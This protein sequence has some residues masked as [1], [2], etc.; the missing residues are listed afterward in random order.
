[1]PR[2]RTTVA[3]AA[4]LAVTVGGCGADQETPAGAS[5]A[6]QQVRTV[7]AKFGIATRDKDYQVICNQLLAQTLVQK[8]EAV[9]LPCEGAL[10]RGL[11]DVKSPTLKINDVSISHGRALVSVHTTAAG[12]QPSDDALQLVLEGRHWKIASLA[13]PSGPQSGTQTGATTTT[14]T[15]SP[16]TTTPGTSTTTTS[17][18]SR[19]TTAT[20]KKK[21]G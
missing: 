17:T 8:I 13:A 12:Q 7:V 18:T 14:T 5:S 15:T 2:R 1:V 6:D 20:T 16:S 10:Q 9:G 19:S 21:G 3:F 11:G 4:T